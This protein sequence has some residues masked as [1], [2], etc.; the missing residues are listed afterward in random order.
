MVTFFCCTFWQ[1][2]K[3]KL[4]R[5]LSVLSEVALGGG[6]APRAGVRGGASCFTTTFRGSRVGAALAAEEDDDAAA[7]DEG[8]A[9]AR[10]ECSGD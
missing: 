4:L 3:L 10:P 1:T 7:D 6:D 5:P 9:G 2:F 8:A